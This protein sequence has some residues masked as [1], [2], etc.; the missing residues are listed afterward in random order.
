MFNTNKILNSD[1]EYKKNNSY[2]YIIFSISIV[3]KTFFSAM[4]YVF[5]FIALAIV[6][7]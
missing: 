6:D 5:N 1:M 7:D 3:I 2:G 4:R